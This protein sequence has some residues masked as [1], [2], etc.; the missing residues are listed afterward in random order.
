MQ[1]LKTILVTDIITC[2]LSSSMLLVMSVILQSISDS[3]KVRTRKQPTAG[4]QS[5][6]VKAQNCFYF[7][8]KATS[9]IGENARTQQRQITRWEK[10]KTNK[11]SPKAHKTYMNSCHIWTFK[12]ETGK[13]FTCFLIFFN[14]A[15]QET[16]E[17]CPVS[18]GGVELHQ[19]QE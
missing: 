19:S 7:K 9:L 14:P 17:T 11:K 1:T 12:I 18:P 6:A 8:T 4:H 15:W 13:N 16:L 2:F 5:T 3:T 10:N